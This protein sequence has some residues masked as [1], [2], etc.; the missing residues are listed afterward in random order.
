ML[1]HLLFHP[2]PLDV[3]LRVL[4]QLLLFSALCT[5]REVRKDFLSPCPYILLPG[6]RV[7]SGKSS[8]EAAQDVGYRTHSP[9]PPTVAHCGATT[10]LTGALCFHSSSKTEVISSQAWQLDFPSDLYKPEVS[11]EVSQLHQPAF[12]VYSYSN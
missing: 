11:W 3:V 4:M 1:P 5:Y 8:L 2:N 12:G 6:E 10:Q 9:P 7:S